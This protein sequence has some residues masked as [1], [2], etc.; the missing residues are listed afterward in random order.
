MLRAFSYESVL[1]FIGGAGAAQLPP[2]SPTPTPAPP[3]VSVPLVPGNQP[4][5]ERTLGYP[6]I[7]G[8]HVEEL[9]TPAVIFGVSVDETP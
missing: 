6:Q 1:V 9:E 3:P 7:L 4:P 2:S 8:F 5:D